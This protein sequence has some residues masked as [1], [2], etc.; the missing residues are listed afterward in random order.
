VRKGGKAHNRM[1]DKFS[2]QE[3]FVGCSSRPNL[4]HMVDKS[5]NSDKPL[6]LKP[7][8]SM[9]HQCVGYRLLWEKADS[10]RIAHICS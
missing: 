9:G 8:T 6:H 4:G 7:E 5:P 2:V 10:E 3:V 1:Q